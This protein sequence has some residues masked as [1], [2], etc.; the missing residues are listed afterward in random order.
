VTT[1]E[2]SGSA[3]AFRVLVIDNRPD[4]RE[5]MRHVV[6]ATGL[7]TPDV[8]EAGTVAEATALLDGGDRDVVVVEIQLPVPLGLETIA[9]LRSHAPGVR[10][11][12]CSFH[13]DEATKERAR[14]EGA[15]AY[16]DKPVSSR[17][18]QDVLRGFASEPTADSG[19]RRG[20]PG[21]EV[22]DARAH[23]RAES[24]RPPVR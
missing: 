19:Q 21:P 15:D 23:P 10:I 1:V 20:R 14:A 24:R 13:R 8:A 17:S 3:P 12:V 7:A 16:L 2:A 18:L 9:A 6:A 4:R 5:L 22:D 11:V